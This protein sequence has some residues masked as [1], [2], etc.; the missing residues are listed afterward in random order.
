MASRES[1][2][3][4]RTIPA[5]EDETRRMT[6]EAAQYTAAEDAD[7]FFQSLKRRFAG[8]KKWTL[9]GILALVG[10][11]GAWEGVVDR[12]A[13]RLKSDLGQ[14]RLTP[15]NGWDRY[16]KIRRRSPLGFASLILR[17]PLQDL[18]RD[19]CERVFSGYRNGDAIREGDW[20]RCKRYMVRAVQLASN[21]SQSRAMLEYADGHILRIN[22]KNFDAVAAFQRAASLQPKW[23]D[24]Y[25][26]LA[27][28]YIYNLGDMERGTQAL[29][30]AR[31]LGSSFGKRELAMMAEACRSR[32]LQE[33]DNANLLRGTGR[34]KEYLKK[35]KSDFDEAIK[36]YLQIAPWDDSTKQITGVQDLLK[37]VDQKLSYLNQSDPLLPWNW[38]K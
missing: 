2:E 37:E 29:D 35:A 4:R 14:G 36:I 23:P 21:D 9:V 38:F 18:L 34:E 10:V 17:R 12:S 25:L 15:D 33:L 26:G 24:P 5:V 7:S 27:R 30:R 13:F 8:A 16:E 32:G 19:S 6:G 1:E 28:T 31:Q 3:T 11:L 20:I 22:R